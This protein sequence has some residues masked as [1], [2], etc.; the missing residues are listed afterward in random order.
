MDF[1]RG[2]TVFSVE[3]ADFNGWRQAGNQIF[4]QLR[5]DSCKLQYYLSRNSSEK[6]EE[7]WKCEFS[8]LVD[9]QSKDEFSRTF[10]IVDIVITRS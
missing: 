5:C 9:N 10:F 4:G 2:Y 7:T 6:C 8:F 1:E 3:T